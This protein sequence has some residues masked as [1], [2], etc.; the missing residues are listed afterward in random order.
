MAICPLTGKVSDGLNVPNDI[1]ICMT[2]PAFDS[3]IYD[4]FPETKLVS[5]DESAAEDE[6][7]EIGGKLE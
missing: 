1:F 5:V 4:R 7:N 3:I 6:I 2:C